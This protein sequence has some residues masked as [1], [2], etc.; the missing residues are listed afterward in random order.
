MFVQRIMGEVKEKR[1]AELG[2][3]THYVHHVHPLATSAILQ[4]ASLSRQK[5]AEVN[6]EDKHR[7]IRNFKHCKVQI[8]NKILPPVLALMGS[9]NM[10]R[11]VLPTKVGPCISQNHTDKQRY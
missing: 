5:P 4:R 3:G 2:S 1:I 6:N 8:S 9:Y 10:K 7:S 11:S